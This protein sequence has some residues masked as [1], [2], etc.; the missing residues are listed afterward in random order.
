LK[1]RG[2][3]EI[4]I[5]CVDGFKGFS[6]SIKAVFPEAEIQLF[7]IHLIRKFI[8]YSA[9]KDKKPFIKKLHLIYIAITEEAAL[10]AMDKL[11]K[12]GGR[13]VAYQSEYGDRTGLNSN[14]FSSILKK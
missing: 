12:T 9:S 7:I 2:V 3:E 10:I 14:N 13:N 1:N 11:K 5:P 8:S 6:E 4:L